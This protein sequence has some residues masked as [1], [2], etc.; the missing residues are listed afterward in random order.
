MLIQ[1]GNVISV[2][3]YTENVVIASVVYTGNVIASVDSRRK[4]YC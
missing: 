4:C 1:A 3:V 2:V